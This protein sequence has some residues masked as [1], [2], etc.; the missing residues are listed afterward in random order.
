MS[1]SQQTRERIHMVH[2]WLLRAGRSVTDEQF[3]HIFSPTAPPIGWHLWHIARFAD[4][5]QSKLNRQ[6]HENPVDDYW[7]SDAVALKWGVDG[8]GFGVFEAGL[9]QG[10]A[11]AQNLIRMAG[12]GAVMDYS[13]LAFEACDQAIKQL[14][15]SQLAGRFYGLF[16]YRYD[17]DSGAVWATDPVE[18]LVAA[19]LVFH[20]SHA[21]RHMGMMEALT[22]LLGQAGTLSV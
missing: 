14:T 11:D 15:A 9:N 1:F 21:S 3:H 20:G 22:G 13:K 6:L 17:R 7:T 4:V 16:N 10:H 8:L 2:H 18:S 5:L 12:R 19:D